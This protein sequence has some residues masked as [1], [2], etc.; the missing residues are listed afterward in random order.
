MLSPARKD[1]DP[2][3]VFE[4]P[5]LLADTRLRGEEDLRSGR[6]IQIVMGDFPDVAQLLQLHD[7]RSL[8]G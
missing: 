8:R 1:F 6:H 3:L 2:E 7:I 4:Q 5:D